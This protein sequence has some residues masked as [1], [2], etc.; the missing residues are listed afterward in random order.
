MPGSVR[1]NGRYDSDPTLGIVRDPGGVGETSETDDSSS[2]YDGKEVAY[3]DTPITTNTGKSYVKTVSTINV[4]GKDTSVCFY[5]GELAAGSKITIKELTTKAKNNAP[6]G[7]TLNSNVLDFTVNTTASDLALT[8]G[9]D[10][11]SNSISESFK[12]ND[13][14]DASAKWAYS[15]IDAS[16]NV[17][18]LS[19]D[20]LKNAGAKFYDLVGNDGIAETVYLGLV[21]GGYGDKDG[22]V[23][24]KI[25][26]PS[27]AGVASLNSSFSAVDQYGLKLNDQ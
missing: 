12:N 2:G 13:T 6:T 19:Y 22:V 1:D 14:R 25:V 17:T 20:P 5:G 7:V 18:D 15:S 10:L 24:G 8:F 11:V 23:N 21:D 4:N 3:S 16:G 9:T 27:T 26:D